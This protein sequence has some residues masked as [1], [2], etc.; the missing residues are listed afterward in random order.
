[1]VVH[2]ASHRAG[3]RARGFT[4]VELITVLAIIAVM[5]G[6]TTLAWRASAVPPAGRIVAQLDSA[7][8]AAILGGA[9]VT[10]RHGAVRVRFRPDGSS[11]GGRVEADGMV[12]IVDPLTGS[13]RAEP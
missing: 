2:A 1:V 3:E 9:A 13:V 8:T 10:W 6:I 7:R 4:L 11:S 5:A 12:L